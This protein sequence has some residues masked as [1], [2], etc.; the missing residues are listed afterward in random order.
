MSSPRD[1]LPD[2]GP[3]P[4]P[5]HDDDESPIP[6]GRAHVTVAG[7]FLDVITSLHKLEAI[8][9]A[10]ARQLDAQSRKP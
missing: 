7:A 8:C 10:V 3:M 5:G 6:A 2:D 1:T 4:L 9:S